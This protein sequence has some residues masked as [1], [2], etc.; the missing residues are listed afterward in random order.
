M[1]YLLPHFSVAGSL[2]VFYGG[3]ERLLGPPRLLNNSLFNRME[4]EHCKQ[5][6]S[7]T[8]FTSSNGMTSTS[9]DEWEVRKAATGP[10]A[11]LARDEFAGRNSRAS[12]L[13]IWPR[14]PQYP[15]ASGIEGWA[16]CP[17][18][19]PIVQAAQGTIGHTIERV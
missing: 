13:L 1:P 6:D 2:D 12:P 8:S 18:P 5:T 17:C 10:R 15:A 16:R 7:L 14:V 9:S 19:S 11:A 4:M 3:L